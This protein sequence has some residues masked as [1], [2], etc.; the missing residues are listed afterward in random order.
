MQ[1]GPL[2][3]ELGLGALIVVVFFAGLFGPREDRAGAE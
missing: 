2:G 3:L 1:R